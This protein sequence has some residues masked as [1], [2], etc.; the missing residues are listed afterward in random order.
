MFQTSYTHSFHKRRNITDLFTKQQEK[1]ET[2]IHKVMKINKL[3]Y[4]KRD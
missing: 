4:I 3:N 2:M 1:E